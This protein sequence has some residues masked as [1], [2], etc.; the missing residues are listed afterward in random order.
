MNL[1]FK[2]KVVNILGSDGV[3]SHAL[4]NYELRPQQDVLPADFDNP[5]LFEEVKDIWLSGR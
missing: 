2:D 3:I 4:E 5:A 1:T